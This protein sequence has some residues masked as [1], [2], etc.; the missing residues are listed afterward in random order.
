LS[1]IE[2]IRNGGLILT[3]LQVYLIA[4]CRIKLLQ[5]IMQIMYQSIEIKT[6][7]FEDGEDFN[8]ENN[9]SAYDF[10]EVG[11]NLHTL[12]K[13]NQKLEEIF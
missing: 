4:V 6:N 13:M 12:L 8:I 5:V 10:E 1:Y 7:Y 9:E 2:R 11:E 3:A